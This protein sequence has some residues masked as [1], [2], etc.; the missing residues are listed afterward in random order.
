MYF[1]IKVVVTSLIIVGAQTL[2][3]K[4]QFFSVLLLSLPITSILAFCWIYY[5]TQNTDKLIKMSYEII[6]LV[7]PSLTFF[8]IFPLC[9]KAKLQFYLALLLAGICTTG[10]YTLFIKIKHLLF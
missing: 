10:F 3:K 8:I 6:W 1:L 2:A 7:I 5:E 4:Y 9:L